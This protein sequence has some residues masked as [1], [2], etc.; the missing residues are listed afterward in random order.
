MSA[1]S[2]PVQEDPQMKQYQPEP[3]TGQED[4]A[5]ASIGFKP[6][7]DELDQPLNAEEATV[8]VLHFLTRMRK[9]V[10]SPKKAVQNGDIF[11]V[12][13]ELQQA[14]AIVNIDAKTREIV[15]YEITPLEKEKKPLPISPK[16][17]ALFFG[18]FVI[19]VVV[20]MAVT[21]FNF[22]I[23]AFATLIQDEYFT[24]YIIYAS[25]I[26][27]VLGGVIWWRRRS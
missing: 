13:V 2:A 8:L 19:A 27:I 16:K 14:N 11:V 26:L 17:L 10:I 22:H 3:Y 9:R 20:M 24:D 25:V 18:T 15:E 7:E 12:D 6:Y 5:L 23:P 21:L 4:R 1:D